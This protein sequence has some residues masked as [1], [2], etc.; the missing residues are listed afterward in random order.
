MTSDNVTEAE[1]VK[2]AEPQSAK[3]VDPWATGAP[4]RE[5]SS[6]KGYSDDPPF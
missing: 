6:Q 2:A 3:K 4:Q 1:S 5:T